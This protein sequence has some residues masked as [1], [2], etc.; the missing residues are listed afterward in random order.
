MN[1]FDGWS[2]QLSTF[3][4][5]GLVRVGPNG[6]FPGRQPLSGWRDDTPEAMRAALGWARTDGVDFFYFDWYYDSPP[7]R[8][9][10]HLN[11]ALANYLQLREHGGVGAALMYVNIPPFVVPRGDWQSTVDRWVTQDFMS[12]DYARVNGKPLLFIID[13]ARFNEQWGGTD[14]VNAALE[15][16]RRTAIAHGLPGVFVVGSIF[17]GTCVDRVGWDYFASM[18]KGESWDALT[19]HAYPA[20]GCERDGAQPYADLVAAG[21]ASW[22]RYADWFDPPAIPEVMAGWDPRPWDERA[23]G[24][25][26]WFDHAPAQFGGFVRDA[27]A[28]VQTHPTEQ[29]EPAPARPIVLV[30]SWNEI[31]EGEEVV[32]NLD[33]GHSYGQALAQAVGLPWSPPPKHTLHVVSSRGATV[34]SKPAGISCPP[35]CTAQFEQGNQVVLTLL[36][37]PGAHLD[38][39]SGCTPDPLTIGACDLILLGDTT[40]QV[41]ATPVSQRRRLTLQI[42]RRIASG[43]LT[44]RDGYDRCSQRE[45]VLIQ[46]HRGGLWVAIASSRTNGNGVY[47][48]TIRPRAGSYRARVARD[49][50]GGH[51]C[52]GSTSQTSTYG[53]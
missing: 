27:V 35:T 1:Y 47:T 38:R 29:V 25:L 41:T 43:R 8:D 40:S 6:Q 37:H 46:R 50:L 17:V 22:D 20:A 7:G 30:T 49:W 2:D 15:A 31:G 21:E 33:D 34:T 24:H 11:R 45:L 44:T 5:D 18:I 39:W 48:L 52:L 10:D 13:S 9:P 42:R 32:P 53:R 51:V 4:F 28:W 36:L 26:W 19:Q 16:L 3:H 23:D 14:G 12:P